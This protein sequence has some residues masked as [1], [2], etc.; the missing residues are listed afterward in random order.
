MSDKRA[1]IMKL[2]RAGKT[3]STTVKLPKLQLFT[4]P[5]AGSRSSTVPMIILQV[6]DHNLFGHQKSLMLSEHDSSAVQKDP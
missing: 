5:L 6:D 4:I 2:Y 3:M 1:A